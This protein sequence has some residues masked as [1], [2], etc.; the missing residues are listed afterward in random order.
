M[1]LQLK[2]IQEYVKLRQAVRSYV[3][4]FIERHG[5]TECPSIRKIAHRFNFPQKM[6]LQICE[7]EGMIINIGLGNQGG[8][9]EYKQIGDYTIE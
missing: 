9:Y 4:R 6:I 3:E 1:K 8:H 5:G 2:K 7:D